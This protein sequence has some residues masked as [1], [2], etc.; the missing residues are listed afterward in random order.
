MLYAI[1][2]RYPLIHPDWIFSR[3]LGERSERIIAEERRLLYVALTRAERSVVI[4]TDGRNKSPFLED[5]EGRGLLDS[6]SWRNFPPLLGANSRLVVTVG[7]QASRGGQ[8][9]YEIRDLLKANGYQFRSSRRPEWVKIV[10]SDG[11][12]IESIREE[13]WAKNADGI[14]VQIADESE[15]LIA[16]FS[17]NRGRWTCVLDNLEEAI[18]TETKNAK[19]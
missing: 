8:S 16:Q 7:N 18:S 1:A 19:E 9:T 13:V 3:V 5:I 2:R 11:F 17:V 10:L 15:K 12:R 6:V 4:F 14:D